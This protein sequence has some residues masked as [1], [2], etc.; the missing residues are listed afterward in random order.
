L[1]AMVGATREALF[2]AARHGGEPISLYAEVSPSAVTVFVRDR[3]P[4]F[5]LESIP[6]DRFGVRESILGRVRRQGGV[7]SVVS[8]PGQGTEVRLTLPIQPEPGIG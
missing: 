1:E 3:G 2:N 4:G 5:D 7:A 6:P 8:K